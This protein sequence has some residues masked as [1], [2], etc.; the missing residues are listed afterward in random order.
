MLR[1]LSFGGLVL[2]TGLVIGWN[3]FSMLRINGVDALKAVSFV[4]FVL[5]LLPIALSFWTA[6]IGFVVQWRGGDSL[7]LTRALEQ[8]PLPWDHLPRT[9]VVMPVYNEDP[10][11]VFAGVKATY[12]SLEQTG[13]LRHFDF[14]LLSDTTDPDTWIKEEVAFGELRREVSDPERLVYRN[15]RENTERKTGNIADFCATW[16]ERYRYMIVFDADSIM[17]GLSLVNLVRLMEANPHV[18][19]VQAPP[20]PINRR[21]LFGRIHQ[22]AMQA[23]SPIF[24]SGL[25][26]WQ[27]GAANYWGH[28][29][30]IR[31]EPFVEHCRLPKLPGKAPLGGSIL[32]HD[33]V[34]AAYM[35]RAGWKVYLASD[36]RG[37][38]EEM[39]SSLIGY[40]ARDRRWCQGNLQHARL[41]LTPGF[42][43]VSRIHILMGLMSYLASPLWLLLLGLTTLEGIKQHTFKH[44]YFS[45]GKSLFPVWQISVREQAIILFLVMM[46]LL[47]IPKLLSLILHAHKPGHGS[48]FGGSL[49]M[50]TS[51]VCETFISSLL[52]PNLALL[53]AKFV[54]GIL[55]GRKVEWNSQDRGE[56]STTFREAFQRHW[57]STLLG[58]SWTLLLALT[59]PTLIWWFSPV[60]AGFLLAI[61]LSALTSR[62]SWGEWA[63]DRGLFLTPEELKPPE[64]LLGF[65]TELARQQTKPWSSNENGLTRVLTDPTA[66]EIHL[67]LVRR[68]ETPVDP[69]LKNH[70]ERLELKARRDG[71]DSLMPSERRDLLLHPEA[72]Q[73]LRGAVLVP[74]QA[75]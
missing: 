49:K 16:G 31:I 38:Y 41:L 51:G 44:A 19:I 73:A 15:R 23:Y 60:L 65:Q 42:H 3:A 37:S 74:S 61:P 71:P 75:A 26:Y 70:L 46:S 36:V 2:L 69:L 68:S 35:R 66:W 27:G 10:T 22:F 34:E 12:E 18:G 4:L 52:A 14:F 32:S 50:I 57:P 45:T 55:M 58:L 11:R 63:K 64:L 30:I 21:T 8:T 56:T 9:A 62:V 25:N 20:L 59:V 6:A 48:K 54:I 28:N 47:L 40:A 67:A 39:P 24:I 5:L 43:F 33:F 7:D 13:L 72:L 53:Q 29:A 1:R 17:T